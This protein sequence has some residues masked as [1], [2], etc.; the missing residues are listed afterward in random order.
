[1]YVCMFDPFVVNEEREKRSPAD[2][3]DL[4]HSQREEA[5]VVMVE[6]CMMDSSR[7]TAKSHACA[8][9]FE[10]KGDCKRL[11]RTYRHVGGVTTKRENALQNHLR[12]RIP[13]PSFWFCKETWFSMD[14]PVFPFAPSAS[15]L[16]LFSKT[17]CCQS[18]AER[19]FYKISHGSISYKHSCH[20]TKAFISKNS[21]TIEST[22]LIYLWLSRNRHNF[23]DHLITT[24]GWIHPSTTSR[25]QFAVIQ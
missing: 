8:R 25:S 22:Q 24:T 19:S 7:A 13:A 2:L 11:W 14:F 6:V 20:S 9:V 21:K 18:H 10:L 17:S 23:S 5:V 4:G 12:S 3:S 1:M 15:F 16:F